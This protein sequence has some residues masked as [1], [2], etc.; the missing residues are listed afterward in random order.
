MVVCTDG[1][2]HQFK[3]SVN[4]YRSKS[5][6]A[7]QDELDKLFQSSDYQQTS[8]S[9]Y[10]LMK[11]AVYVRQDILHQAVELFQKNNVEVYGASHEADFQLV[12][13]EKTGF[14][15]GTISVYSDIFVLGSKLFVDELK[16]ESKLGNCMI[17]ERNEVMAENAFT[18]ESSKW[19]DDDLHIYGTLNGCDW[20]PRLYNLPHAKIEEFMKRWLKSK[21]NDERMNLLKWI[22]KNRYWPKGG[23]RE[24]GTG[25]GEL[26]LDFPEKFMQCINF[27]KYAPVFRYN[28][29]TGAIEFG[30]LNDIPESETRSWQEL[31]G[32]DPNEGLH[33]IDLEACYNMKIWARIGKPLKPLPLPED[34]IDPTRSGKRRITFLKSP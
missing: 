1:G 29:S 11:K 30:P 9:M 17:L 24:A 20:L 6:D 14:T 25:K 26:A 3:Q 23:G 7:A 8:D 10:K 21:S 13:W 33:N 12:H 19:S 2:C 22:S 32:F 15:D 27:A 4:A 28:K 5:R 16:T 34:P 18:S 31:V